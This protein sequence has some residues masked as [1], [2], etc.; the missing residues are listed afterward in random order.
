MTKKLQLTKRGKRVR[1]VSLI[2][3]GSILLWGIYLVATHLWFTPSGYCWGT[4]DKC[5]WGS[6]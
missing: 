5:L 1:T 4:A 2:L 3:L 6:L